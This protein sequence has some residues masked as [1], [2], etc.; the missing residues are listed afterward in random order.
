MDWITHPTNKTPDKT[1][2]L[3]LDFCKLPL[4]GR[5]NESRLRHHFYILGL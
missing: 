1:Q 4:P 2:M 5:L 3:E